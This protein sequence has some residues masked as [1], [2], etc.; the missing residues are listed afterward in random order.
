MSKIL[1]IS[2]AAY[3]I[4]KY[5]HKLMDSFI[6]SNCLADLEILV[7]DDGSKDHTAQ[8]ALEYEKAYPESIKLVSKENGGHG[9]T[10]N[11]GIEI[12]TGKYFRSV[13]GDDWVNSANLKGL[14]STLKEID[15]DMVICDYDKCYSNGKIKT[16]KFDGIEPMKQY[17]FDDA[18]K[19]IP[20]MCYHTIVYR[21]D[22][23]QKNQIKIDEH[24][25]YVD[26]EYDM[27][28]IQYIK[29]ILYYDK[30]I[31]CY[32]LGTNEQSVSP[33]SRKKNIGHENTVAQS[34][35]NLYT[36]QEDKISKSKR[37]YILYGV[38]DFCVW[39]IRSLFFFS[40]S[41]DRKKDIQ[42]F[43]EKVKGSSLAVYKKMEDF[44]KESLLIK[45]LRKTEYKVYW[46]VKLYKSIK[47]MVK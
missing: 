29:T 36:G 31:Y 39:H 19:Q 42:L 41:S 25:F 5:I 21:T 23:L 14:V 12:A 38:A 28:P 20:W 30:S 6:Q 46:I 17:D 40:A 8:L 13:D 9:S 47:A 3:N 37:E 44:G 2:I 32:R 10:I 1:S 26:T 45:A 35:L 18:I 7:I 11:K 43:D 15:V 33:E 34:L 22:I 16:I 27:Y 24:C 4:E